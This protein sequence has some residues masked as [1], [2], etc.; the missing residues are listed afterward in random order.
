MRKNWFL[1]T[2]TTLSL[3]Y[4]LFSGALSGSKFKQVRVVHLR[5]QN[6]LVN[7]FWYHA[8]QFVGPD[9]L[10]YWHSVCNG[11]HFEQHLSMNDLTT[12]LVT[13]VAR[14]CTMMQTRSWFIRSNYHE[15]Q[16]LSA[17]VW[18]HIFCSIQCWLCQWSPWP[19]NVLMS[20]I[21]VMSGTK[22]IFCVPLMWESMYT[23]INLTNYCKLAWNMT[24]FKIVSRMLKR[25]KWSSFYLTLYL[26]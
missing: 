2:T 5:Y 23:M 25:T 17:G 21:G 10:H 11:F 6:L 16:T 3:C 7:L 8:K 14:K 24:S 22:W 19:W 4:W 1:A 15:F 18:H 12:K 20:Q 26:S 9:H 13:E